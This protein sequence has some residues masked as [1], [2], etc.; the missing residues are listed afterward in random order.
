MLSFVAVLYTGISDSSRGKLQKITKI[1][2]SK[3]RPGG[4]PVSV[5]HFPSIFRKYATEFIRISHCFVIL[6]T[7]WLLQN[8]CNTP[9][10]PSPAGKGDRHEAVVDEGRWTTERSLCAYLAPLKGEAKKTHFPS[11]LF[12]KAPHP[13]RFASHLPR[14]GRFCEIR[15]ATHRP[16]GEGYYYPA[17]TS[18]KASMW[19]K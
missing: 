2:T 18:A 6:V 1:I 10:K 7:N 14:R 4:N 5:W 19:K 17:H 8:R 13:S 16:C 12:R 9:Q 15:C 3:L 11:A